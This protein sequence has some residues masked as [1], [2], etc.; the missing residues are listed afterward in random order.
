MGEFNQHNKD[1]LADW[2]AKQPRNRNPNTTIDP[3]QIENPDHTNVV[4]CPVCFDIPRFPIISKCNHVLCNECFVKNF[5]SKMSHR[6]NDY[7]TKC[8]EC[9]AHLGITD[10][11]TYQHYK[12]TNPNSTASSFY[13]SIKVVC[14]NAGCNQFICFDELNEHEMFN[15]LF[16]KIVCPAKLCPAVGPAEQILNHTLK[17]PLHSIWCGV[18]YTKYS[19][20]VFGHNCEKMLQ[21]RII[22]GNKCTKELLIGHVNHESGDIL[23]PNEDKPKSL[24]LE[25]IDSINNLIRLKRGMEMF[26]LYEGHAEENDSDSAGTSGESSAELHLPAIAAEARAQLIILD[27]NAR[28]EPDFDYDFS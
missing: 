8:P 24:D 17:C 14:D 16:R 6:G 21:R 4:R 5:T 19:C 12:L 27:E 10:V 3:L 18:C 26:K 13:G 7:F 25:A 28:L 20:V 22:M 15:C 23:L 9:R 2:I 1:R 11:Q